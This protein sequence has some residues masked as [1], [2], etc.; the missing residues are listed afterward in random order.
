LFQ[1]WWYITELSATGATGEVHESRTLTL[2]FLEY[3][4]PKQ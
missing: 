1:E 4:E 2:S 3:T